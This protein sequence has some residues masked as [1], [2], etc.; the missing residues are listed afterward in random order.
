MSQAEQ[1]Q[2]FD[3]F[4]SKKFA[5]GGLGLAAVLGVVRGHRGTID[6]E[7]T[8]GS[9]TSIRVLLPAPPIRPFGTADS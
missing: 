4:F 1:A 9:G 8:P 6:V 5:G 7:S 3:P 2:M